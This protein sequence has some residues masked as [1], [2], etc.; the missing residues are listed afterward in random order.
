MPTD[1]DFKRLV[2]ARMLKTGEAYTTARAHLLQRRPRRRP[3][4]PTVAAVPPITDPKD[5]AR[6]A[7]M[8]DAAIK[9]K[10]GCTWKRWVDALDDAGARE[11]PHRKIAELVQEKFKIDDWWA[12]TVAVGYERIIGLREIGQ[13]RG[14]GYEATK[15]KTIAAPIGALYRAFADPRQRRKWLPVAKLMIR[16]ATRDKSMRLG[17]SDETRVQLNFTSKGDARSQVAVQHTRLPDQ[18]ARER[19]KAFWAERLEALA[20]LLSD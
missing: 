11:M 17:W 6:R 1:K 18:Q 3:A 16:T 7:G 9:A 2:R 19:M 15:S 10:T 5:Y 13:R 20:Q 14:G 12:Q 4:T 8:S